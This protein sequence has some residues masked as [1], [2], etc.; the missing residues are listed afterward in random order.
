MYF[1]VA[2]VPGEL[3]SE[4][5]SSLAMIKISDELSAY[6]AAAS[7]SLA[8][9][10]RQLVGG[11]DKPTVVTAAELPPGCHKDFSAHPI[12]LIDTPQTL[13][14]FRTERGSTFPY[15]S[16]LVPFEQ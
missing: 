15:A 1:L 14:R 6:L 2:R 9:G 5:D 13:E 8:E 4:W 7:P 3:K 12:L 10:L 16:H 11:P